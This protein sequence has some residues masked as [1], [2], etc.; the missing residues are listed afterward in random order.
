MSRIAFSGFTLVAAHLCV[1]LKTSRTQS[2]IEIF[3]P[4]QLNSS[5]GFPLSI[6]RFPRNLEGKIFFL[7]FFLIYVILVRLIIDTDLSGMSEN[8]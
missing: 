7:I 2:A 8:E 6:K 1:F 4:I 3:F 5:Q